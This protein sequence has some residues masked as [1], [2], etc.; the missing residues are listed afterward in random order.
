MKKLND[1]KNLSSTKAKSTLRLRIF[2]GPNGSG[3]STVINSVR[4]YKTSSGKLDFGIY[5]NADDIV[6]QLKN[7]TFT[8]S[9]FEIKANE[10]DFINT[11]LQSGLIDKKFSKNVFLSCFKFSEQKL[12]L[13]Q[14]NV[15]TKTGK[16]IVEKLGQI[17][18]DYLRKKLLQE[19]KRFSFETV[20][21]HTSKLDIMK[22]A[23]ENGYKV[24]LYFVSTNS[25][26]INKSR[27]ELRV[28]KGGHDVDPD[29]IEGRYYRSLD[30]L[31][32]AAQTCYQVFFVDNSG[33]D[34][35]PNLFTNFKVVDGK[36]QWKKIK[37]NDAPD[38]FIK[39]YAN[40]VKH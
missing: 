34:K 3:K 17:I 36:K 31:Y 2:A 14:V 1:Q 11:A 15:T 19:K 6:V 9:K 32:E 16:G 23:K 18:A 37:A 13:H 5:I 24:Y 4:Q 26:E 12:I 27:V 30:L 8:F 38:W 29:K 22:Q 10:T 20:F 28:K 7:N 39:Y 21:S 25:P 33:E 35:E 40:K